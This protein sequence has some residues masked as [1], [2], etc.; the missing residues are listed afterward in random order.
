V[1]LYRA[2][3]AMTGVLLWFKPNSDHNQ[4][5][6][7]SNFTNGYPIRSGHGDSGDNQGN[8]VFLRSTTV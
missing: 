2:I 6:P 5:F 3:Q 1:N 8:S 7:S 4:S